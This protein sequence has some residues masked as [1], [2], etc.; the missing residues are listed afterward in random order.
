MGLLDFFKKGT[1]KV[2]PAQ[3][4]TPQTNQGG[5]LNNTGTTP[6]SPADTSETKIGP[7]YEMY[8]VKEGDWLSKIAG[9]YYGDVH[10]W[11]KI[12][13]ANRDQLS[14]PDKVTPG[15]IIKIPLD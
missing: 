8:T 5:L 4:P 3:K 7:K 15:T 14:D 13:E 9:A 11:P 12:F 1:T 10:A 2:N 6:T